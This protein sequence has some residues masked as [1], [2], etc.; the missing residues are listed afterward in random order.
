MLFRRRYLSRLEKDLDRWIDKGWVVSI[1]R[2]AILNDAAEAAARD[3]KPRTAAL[4]AMLGA[5]LLAAGAL[6]FVAANWD[7]MGRADRLAVLFAALTA[8]FAGGWWFEGRGGRP[9]VGQGLILLGSVLFGAG[10]MLVAQI[11]HIQAHFPDGILLW[12]AG[13]LAAAVLIPN[14]GSLWLAFGLAGIWSV[15]EILA[16][17]AVPHWP[18]LPAWAVLAAVAVRCRWWTCLDF[19]V[20]VLAGWYALA[21]T[22]FAFEV[23]DISGAGAAAV[24]MVPALAAWVAG[25]AVPRIGW[26]LHALGLLGAVLCAYIVTQPDLDAPAADVALGA[27]GAGLGLAVLAALAVRWRGLDSGGL[28]ERLALAALAGLLAPLRIGLETWSGSVAADWGMIAGFLLLVV[29]LAVHGGRSGSPLARR[30]AYGAFA[31]DIVGLYYRGDVSLLSLFVFFTL[32][33]AALVVSALRLEKQ[34]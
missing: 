28:W 30:V 11:Y 27:A 7:Q 15:Q 24:L 12:G 19:G 34:A 22:R 18:F 32:A 29:G 9:R 10:I 8:A 33:G 25:D 6:A 20:L 14:Q 21:G 31:V 26:L 13:A 16:F 5:L 2:D 17:D 23:A 4:L 1:R 3:G